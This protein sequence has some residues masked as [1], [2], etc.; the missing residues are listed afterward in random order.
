MTMRTGTTIMDNVEIHNCSQGD[1][2]ML[3]LDFLQQLLDKAPLQ[4]VLCIMVRD[5]A[6]L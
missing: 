3:H 4:I 2:E 6:W 1:T 5:G